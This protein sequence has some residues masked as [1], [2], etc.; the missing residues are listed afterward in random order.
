VGV[1]AVGF[2]FVAALALKEP[3][4][5]LGLV[6]ADSVKQAGHAIIMTVL[7]LSTVGRLSGQRILG[8]LL[9]VVVAALA[10][11]A[12]VW[13]LAT[14]LASRLPDGALGEALVVAVA[15]A[16]GGLFYLLA[17]RLLRVPEAVQLL[18]AVRARIGLSPGKGSVP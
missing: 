10:M 16:F 5:F 13:Q 3:L 6:L 8:T 2:Y 14:W 18:G 7:L 9:R 15:A 1:V 4:G 17:L 11:A 12:L